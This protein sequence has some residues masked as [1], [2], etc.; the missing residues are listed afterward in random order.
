MRLIGEILGS[1]KLLLEFS[2]D[3]DAK[4]TD[5]NSPLRCACE[6]NYE[7]E[8]GLLL[9]Y[10]ADPNLSTHEWTPLP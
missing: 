7:E 9:E 1:L 5:G 8:T 4:T 10:G 6:H 3:P 2:A